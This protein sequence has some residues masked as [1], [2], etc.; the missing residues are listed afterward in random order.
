MVEGE[1]HFL[2]FPSFPR[3]KLNATIWTTSMEGGFCHFYEQR[4]FITSAMY[5]LQVIM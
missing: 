5:H 1:A 4:L 3:F 2:E